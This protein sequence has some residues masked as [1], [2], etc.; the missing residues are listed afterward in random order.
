[1]SNRMTRFRAWMQARWLLVAMILLT[2]GVVAP[3]QGWPPAVALPA[4]V[5][6]MAAFLLSVSERRANFDNAAW[7]NR[8]TAPDDR[9]ST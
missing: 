1:M 8:R 6:A 7:D 9:D 2:V 5:A 3:S 4:P